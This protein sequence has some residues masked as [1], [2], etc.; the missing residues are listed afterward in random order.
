[1]SAEDDGFEGKGDFP[2]W[3]CCSFLLG[4]DVVV[5]EVVGWWRVLVGG[6]CE[7]LSSIRVW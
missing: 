4:V 3:A 5:V 7:V 6:D 2:E 1:M